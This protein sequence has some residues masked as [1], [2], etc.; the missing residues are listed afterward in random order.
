M[1]R[2]DRPEKIY[3]KKCIFRQLQASFTPRQATDGQATN[4]QVTFRRLINFLPLPILY[5]IVL[6]RLELLLIKQG[7]DS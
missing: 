7:V 3:T 5:T 6:S 2:G 1:I 4:G